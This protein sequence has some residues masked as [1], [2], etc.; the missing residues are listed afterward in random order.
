ML[1]QV[2]IGQPKLFHFEGYKESDPTQPIVASDQMKSDDFGMIKRWVGSKRTGLKKKF[3][4]VHENQ[5]LDKSTKNL[6]VKSVSSLSKGSTASMSP[7]SSGENPVVTTE[8][9]SCKRME[10]LCNSEDGFIGLSR[11][12]KRPAFPL[13]ASQHSSDKNSQLMFSKFNVKQSSKVTENHFPSRCNKKMLISSNS[14]IQE[15]SSFIH[16]NGPQHH[17]ISPEGKKFASLRKPSSTSSGNKKFS[18]LRTKL[19]SVRHASVTELKKNSGRK[20]LNIKNTRTSHSDDEEA[21]V[22]RS[23]LRRQNSMVETL[24][25]RATLPEKSSGQPLINRTRVLKIPKKVGRVWNTGEEDMTSNESDSPSGGNNAPIDTSNDVE[26][27]ADEMMDEFASEPNYGMPDGEAFASFSK[28][29]D[30]AFPGLAD[31]S[32]VECGS[33]YY[34][35]N[36]L[37]VLNGDR[38]NVG[39]EMDADEAQGNYFVDVEPI[40]IPGPPGSFLPSP[41]RM[42]SEEL[43]GHSSLTTCRLQSSEE[44]HG[45]VDMDSSDSPVSGISGVSNSIAGRSNPISITNLSH[46]QGSSPFKQVASGDRE[47]NLLESMPE[48]SHEARDIQLCCC[49][50]K[51]G[52]LQGVS[53]NYQESQIL[54]RRTMT[55]NGPKNEIHCLNVGPATL[56]EKVSNPE[57]KKHAA[58]SYPPSPSTP[59]PV[60][61][62]MGK[63]LMVV[64]KDDNLSPRT[65]PVAIDHASSRWSGENGRNEV[66]S[67]HHNLSQVNL[68]PHIPVQFNSSD[69]FK[70]PANHGPMLPSSNFVGSLASRCHGFA[71]GFNLIADQLGSKIRLDSRTIYDA[72]R[73]G[74]E[75]SGGK[76][77]DIIVIDESPETKAAGGSVRAAAPS[78]A[79]HSNPF[80]NYQTR[81]YPHFTGSPVVQNGNNTNLGKWNIAEGNSNSS[82]APLPSAVH[83]RSSSIYFSPGFS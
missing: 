74:T 10:N 31:S 38:D 82:T 61:R 6:R 41:G 67:F 37:V 7:I 62:L 21:F 72:E 24:G 43:Q 4:L 49:A 80:Y 18:S 3:N 70:A 64:N 79:L 60:L 50:R 14:H 13:L 34:N 81:V 9:E 32:N 66:N 33:H 29:L 39:A 23:A 20:L 46:F 26:E 68:Q 40:P 36:E 54:R 51:D 42:G 25:G 11:L 63:N 28:S 47:L 2:E 44:G 27:E 69:G 78:M 15:D 12:R 77:K 73:V 17:G 8:S 53:L 75:S 45:V 52:S 19:L 1:L 59:N 16:P 35:S 58:N 57:P 56:S 30:T 83:L 65:M 5:H 48:M 76:H 55:S 22:S 71:S